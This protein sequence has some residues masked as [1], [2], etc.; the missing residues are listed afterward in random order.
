MIHNCTECELPIKKVGRLKVFHLGYANVRVCR[1]CLRK[2]R[3]EF[4]PSYPTT[5]LGLLNPMGPLESGCL[6]GQPDSRGPQSPI[7][8]PAQNGRRTLGRP[9]PHPFGGIEKQR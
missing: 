7:S 8:P 9:L 5:P 3:E 2:G 1:A 4:G 6:P